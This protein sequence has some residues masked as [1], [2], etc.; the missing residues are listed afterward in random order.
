M[1]ITRTA[2]VALM[3]GVITFIVFLPTLTCDFV[4][5]DDTGYIVDNVS[6]RH[7]DAGLLKSAF[8]SYLGGFWIPLVWISYALDYHFWGM[9]PAGYHLTNNLLHAVVTGLV[10]LLADRLYRAADDSGSLAVVKP[11]GSAYIYPLTLILAALIFGIHPMRVESVAW[12]TERK[13]VLNGVFSLGAILAYLHYAGS[14][15]GRRR[16]AYILAFLLFTLS[17]MAKQTSVVIPLLL[18]VLDWFPL[19][20][21]K[22]G[23][24]SVVLLEKLPFLALSVAMTLATI[25]PKLQNSSLTSLHSFGF[26]DRVL[27]SGNALFEYC[28]LLLFPAGILPFYL[29]PW[30][31][32][33]SYLVKTLIVGVATLLTVLLGM[34]RRWIVATWLCFLIPTLPVLA[35]FH[36]GIQH[37][38][39]AR[40]TY[41]PSVIPSI[42][43][44]W[45][46]VAGCRRLRPEAGQSSMVAVL[47]VVVAV[48]LW[49]GIATVRLI[50]VWENPATFW[51]RVIEYNP[52]WPAYR[53]RGVYYTNIRRYNDAIRDFTTALDMAERL[54]RQDIFNLYAFRGLAY[55]AAGKNAEALEDFSEAIRRFPHPAY[56][57]NRAIVLERM[58]RV[59]EAV[60]DFNRSG[61]VPEEIVWF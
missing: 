49:Y 16:R 18:L 36:H 39:A 19:R 8:G 44:A 45:L 58:G 12:V 59:G 55:K 38:F 7:L 46:I 22:A 31:L 40:F 53:D 35:F 3:A 33:S 13:D 47:A 2:A 34:K 60:K 17:L 4:F 61:A 30:P 48:W 37:A 51:T 6:I 50:P 1:T 10:P 25:V 52:I 27:V 5:L 23:S 21:F 57:Y 54:K 11:A 26:G 56:Y 42:V 15:D 28:R 32:P 41:L 9:N 24:T 29:L 20:R 14:T 43:A